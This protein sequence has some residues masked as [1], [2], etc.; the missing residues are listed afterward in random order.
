M[1]SWADEYDN[2]TD[3]DLIMIH[4]PVQCWGEEIDVWD[5][6]MIQYSVDPGDIGVLL[7]LGI[8]D[9]EVLQHHCKILMGNVIMNVPFGSFKKLTTTI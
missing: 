2:F 1:T 8:F 6:N 4:T 3:G 5:L 7:D 9:D